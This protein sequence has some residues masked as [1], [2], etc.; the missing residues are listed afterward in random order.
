LEYAEHC[1]YC[2]KNAI[3]TALE[4]ARILKIKNELSHTKEG[5]G[6]DANVDHFCKSEGSY[7]HQHPK[8]CTKE[9]KS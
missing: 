9:D 7:P 5:C 1:K 8:D 2:Q 3:V 6:C 4:L